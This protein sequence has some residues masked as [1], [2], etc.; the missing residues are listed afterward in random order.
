MHC[1]EC[2]EALR[3]L[4]QNSKELDDRRDLALHLAGCEDCARFLEDE[5]FLDESIAELLRREAP[6]ELRESILAV[7]RPSDAVAGG[8]SFVRTLS[9]LSWRD[10]LRF[11]W[12][13][14]T[15]DMS[16]RTW[17]EAIAFA[18]LIMLAIYALRWSRG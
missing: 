12:W 11:F 2:R 3:L 1:Q 10:R 13:A 5:T 7:A 16:W 8:S 6:S 14:G 9:S 15:R 4:F 18:A 17:V